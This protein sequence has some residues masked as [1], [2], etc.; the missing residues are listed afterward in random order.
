[1]QPKRCKKVVTEVLYREG[2]AKYNR[3]L[4]LSKIST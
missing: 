1:M 2:V 3:L 4:R